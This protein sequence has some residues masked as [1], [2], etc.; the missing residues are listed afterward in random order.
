MAGQSKFGI[1]VY[2][3]SWNI[4]KRNAER[5]SPNDGSGIVLPLQIDKTWPV[6]ANRIDSSGAVWKISGQSRVA[7]QESVTTK[8][9]KFDAF[10]IETKFTA[11]HTNDHSRKTDAT[12]VMWYSP[13]IDHWVKRSTVFRVNGHV[14]QNY[15]V[16]LTSYGRKQT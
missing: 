8:A 14:L 13:A 9:G 10:V 15:V 16:E 6:Q 1:I 2:D 4:L 3:T 7:R 5:F 11:Q 12:V